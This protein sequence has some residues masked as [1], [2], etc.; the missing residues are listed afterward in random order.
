MRRLALLAALVGCKPSAAPTDLVTTPLPDTRT[1][2]EARTATPA[3]F[4]MFLRAGDWYETVFCCVDGVCSAGDC[5]ADVA[6]EQLAFPGG[7]VR[8][9]ERSE[10]LACEAA[11]AHERRTLRGEIRDGNGMLGLWP[12]VPPPPFERAPRSRSSLADELPPADLEALA[13]DPVLAG[14]VWGSVIRYAFDLDDDGEP[15]DLMAL[16]QRGGGLFLKRAA[17]SGA[18][19]YQRVFDGGRS[20]ILGTIDV[21]G[22]GLRELVVIA[23]GLTPTE[24]VLL[25]VFRGRE[26]FR[27]I[28]SCYL[29]IDRND[30]APE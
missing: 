9:V 6:I 4:A 1:T 14:E 12:A 20:R 11:P 10:K 19:A 8:D 23:H 26:Q 27:T 3:T 18:P 21:D 22:D 29:P 24:V 2:K 5:P 7:D 25:D 30:P 13:A 17:E 16:D 15:E 28:W